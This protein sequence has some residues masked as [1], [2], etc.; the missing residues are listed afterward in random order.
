MKAQRL[1]QVLRELRQRLNGVEKPFLEAE[2]F[3]QA[4]L[5][6]TREQIHM[7]PEREVDEIKIMKLWEF[8]R[9]REEGEPFAY[10]VGFK[11]FYGRQFRV[12]P[13]VLI[14]RPETELVIEEVFK[15]RPDRSLPFQIADF[16][17]GSG[18]IGL[19]LLHEFSNAHLTCV[20]PSP[21]AREY[22]SENIRDQG[23]E[24]RVTVATLKVED[25]EGRCVFDIVVAN[26]PYVDPKSEHVAEDVRK[27]EPSIALF[28]DEEGFG[29]YRRW[30]QRMGQL[31]KPKGLFAVEIGCDQ[32][33]KLLNFLKSQNLWQDIRLHKDLS[34]HDRVV[35]GEKI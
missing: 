29:C 31:I 8:A 15:R 28:A 16:G 25:F 21:Q 32:G 30:F 10:I 13:G 11:D 23:A 17:A 3:L 27:Y 9:R 1:G 6:L 7:A 14:P 35:S 22:L 26:P 18:C 34:G 33:Q 12:G 5:H 24:G 4:V 20:E 2:M 19:S